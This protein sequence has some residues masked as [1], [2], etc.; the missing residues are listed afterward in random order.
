M[1][2]INENFLK[3]QSSY[4]FSEIA[5]RV[6]AYQRAHPEQEIIRLGIGDVTR[7]LPPAC[8][9]AFHKAV[10]EM[11]ADSTFRGYGPEQGYAFLREKI[12]SSISRRAAPISS[13]MRSSSATA[14]SAIP[15]TSRSSLPPISG[16]PFPTRSTRFTWTPTSW[17]GRSGQFEGDRYE[18]IVYL[19][20]TDEN[21]FIPGRSRTPRW[22]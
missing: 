13:P 17:P 6:T 7:A 4:L 19:D 22:T 11:G 18:G 2:R 5:K 9:R 8:I 16:L 21:S 20:S 15:A 3:L 10:D 12:A 1:I 14:P